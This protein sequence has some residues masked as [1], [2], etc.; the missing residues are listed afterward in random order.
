MTRH[1]RIE[2]RLFGS[3]APDWEHLLPASPI[4][5][6]GRPAARQEANALVLFQSVAV[7]AELIVQAN[8]H[9]VNREVD[10]GFPY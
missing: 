3:S 8:L 4:D 5:R 6:L 2:L 1:R 10:V 7:A 9:R